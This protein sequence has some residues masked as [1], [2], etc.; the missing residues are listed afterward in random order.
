[1]LGSWVS[2]LL[3]ES[4]AHVIGLDRDW[5]SSEPAGG[6]EAVT[7]D[8]ADARLVDEL[9]E[10]VDDV[11]HLAAQSILGLGL[12]EPVL[13][14]EVNAAATWQLLD[15]C[16]DREVVAVV[17][18]SDK[19]YGDAGGTPYVETM[20]LAATDPYSASKACAD[21]AARSFAQTYDL[22]VAVTRC[23]NLYG[24]GD[25]NWSRL[26]P[27]TI[28][29]VL[30]GERPI[31]RSDGLF[32]R[33]YLH[34]A[35]AAEANLML[36]QRLAADPSIGGQAFNFSSE[37]R[38]TALEVVDHILEAADSELEPDIR[39]EASHEIR[40]QRVDA[41]KARDVLGWSPR[42][43]MRESMRPTVQWYAEH[44]R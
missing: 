30:Q 29:S 35:D 16:R 39:N 34:V 24:P 23:A 44:L 38:F 8:V 9:I 13:T 28:R 2:K 41:S 43:T 40:E 31:I 15:A 6:V 36:A 4:S 14:Y 17:A 7:G 37:E 5:S 3:A 27:G 20:P 25:R 19:A 18:S 26:V 11:F 12:T 10:G 33:D 21:V 42:H 1:M 22:P 32:V